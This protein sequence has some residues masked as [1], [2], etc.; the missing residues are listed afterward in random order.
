MA[1]YL[2]IHDKNI[3]I[4]DDNATNILLMQAIL[5][6]EGF[7]NILSASSA[8]EAYDV[9]DDQ[10]INL[11]LMDIVMPEIDGL[12][13]TEAIR[14]NQKYLQIPIIMVTATDDDVTLKKSFDLGVVDFIRK[15][16]NQVELIAR[17]STTLQSQEKDSFI[18]Q[19]SRFDAMEEVIGMLAHQWRQPLSVINAIIGTIQM[20]QELEVLEKDTLETSL[21]DIVMH[22]TKLSDMITT[23]REFFKSDVSA[24]LANPNE[25]ISKSLKLVQE[26]IEHEHIQFHLNLG[27]MEPVFYIQNLLIQALNN[28]LINSKEAHIRNKTQDPVITIRSFKQNGKVNILIEDNAGGIAS[29]IIEYI[30]EP[31][32]TTKKEKNGKGLGLYL[33]KTILTQQLKGNISVTSQGDKS[34]FLI[35][36]NP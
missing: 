9:L 11:I 15:P 19:H 13:A 34:K 20:Q 16:V 1:S 17:I 12:E 31:Y 32:F 6:E 21:K 30:F 22:T 8:I 10:S 25:A 35:S 29:N 26:N 18:L 27:E 7:K 28:I 2:S 23:F 33:A 5:E 14:S 24:S 4:V 3:L 36:F